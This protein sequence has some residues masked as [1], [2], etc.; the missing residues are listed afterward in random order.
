VAGGEALGSDLAGHAEE[1][2]EF[3]VG[4]AVGAG[5]G[6]AAGEILLDER[7]HYAS[8]ELLFEVY[9]V[10][11]KI[12]V[13]GDTLGVVDVV[14][15]AATVLRGAVALEFGEAALI[16]ELH[17]EADDRA[18]LLEEDRGDGG[19]VDTTGH[20]YCDEAG[21]AFGGG[22]PRKRVELEVRGHARSILA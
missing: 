17:G 22:R 19:G 7:A 16:P 20:G 4:V 21:S 3:H 2:L 5:D 9:D 12:Q 14:E 8:F 6:C 10:V 18:V 11:G 1:R 13:L 15:R